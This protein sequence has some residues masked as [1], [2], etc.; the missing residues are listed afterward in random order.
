MRDELT[1]LD[2]VREGN[3]VL[4]FGA[5]GTRR[6]NRTRLKKSNVTVPDFSG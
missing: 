1:E 2:G 5:G 6:R 4:G 3:E